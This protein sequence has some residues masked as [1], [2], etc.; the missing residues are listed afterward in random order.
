MSGFPENPG[1]GGRLLNAI[2]RKVP[3]FICG[4]VMLAESIVTCTRPARRSV[5]AA[6]LVR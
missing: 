4:T 2:G 6:A 1:C 3:A 5:L